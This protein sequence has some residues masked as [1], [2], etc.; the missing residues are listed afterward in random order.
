MVTAGLAWV[1]DWRPS[2]TAR[3]GCGSSPAAWEAT[4]SAQPAYRSSPVADWT[5]ATV[6]TPGPARCTDP[7]TST[8]AAYAPV[9][10]VLRSTALVRC[11]K[12]DAPGGLRSTLLRPAGGAP[13]GASPP[14]PAV[15]R[16]P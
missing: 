4:A 10:S 14:V 15:V 6:Y 5:L 1:T 13:G 8:N 7:V 2:N 16:E 11:S 9:T 12:A 3:V